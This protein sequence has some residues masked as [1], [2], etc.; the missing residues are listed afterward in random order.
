MTMICFV[1]L[2][3]PICDV[4]F[5]IPKYQNIH[6]QNLLTILKLIRDSNH[7]EITRERT[8]RSIRKKKP[9]YMLENWSIFHNTEL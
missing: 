3:S 6:A 4:N 8:L 2:I 7:G 1:V 5:Y 9:N